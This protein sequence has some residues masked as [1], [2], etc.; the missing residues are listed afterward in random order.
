M[1]ESATTIGLTPAAESL[2][3]AGRRDEAKRTFR[4]ALE[5]QPDDARAACGLVRQL[6]SERDL[7]GAAEIAQATM[8]RTPFDLRVAALQ[9][10]IGLALFSASLW[11]DAEPWLQR[12][13]ALEPWDPSL[14][15]AYQHVRRPACSP[16]AVRDPAPGKML[17]DLVGDNAILHQLYRLIAAQD[18]WAGNLR[19][20]A[21]H[22]R[23]LQVQ[24]VHQETRDSCQWLLAALAG[25]ETLPAEQSLAL[26]TVELQRGEAAMSPATSTRER[27]ILLLR[28]QLLRHRVLDMVSAN[29]AQIPQV[30][31]LIKTDPRTEDL[32]LL[33]YLCYRSILA[34]CQGYRIM[35]HASEIPRGARWEKLLRHLEPNIAV[36][37]QLLGNF[38]ILSAA[39]QSD[40]WR[41]R[42]LIEHGG[43][44]FD[45]DL[46]LLRSPQHL[47]SHVCVMA[48]ERQEPEYHEVLGVSA[49]G[50][51]PGSQFLTTWLDA[52]PSVFNPSRY[53]AHSTLLAHDLALKLPSLVRVLD[54]RAFYYP[55][56]GEQAM[57]WLFDPAEC[58]SEDQLHEHLAASTGV[59]LF[60]SH[61]N[62]VHWA[63]RVT[64][65]DI[66][67]PRCNLAQ[68]M[69]P[70]L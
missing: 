28:Q 58:L 63:N 69:R 10:E 2:L 51:E 23:S 33:Q 21:E 32:P 19:K 13:V 50:A 54:H 49:I 12:A 17:A 7:R 18:D 24:T 48:L 56:W 26:L 31:H 53:V 42:Q 35:L 9:R 62:F 64:E 15:S 20:A 38:R 40:V 45:W 5:L 39:H 68:L 47:R 30:V 14:I 52:M 6:L 57:R 1:S 25:L 8:V 46:L 37:P 55:G 16:P 4:R 59:H 43:F 27:Q 65:K 61:A 22:I 41:L 34:H 70:Y 67:V 66:E 29:G 44:Y 60:C 36:P 11:E 3:K